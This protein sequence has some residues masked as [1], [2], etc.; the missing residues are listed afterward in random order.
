M[1]SVTFLDQ[2]ICLC[3]QWTLL[4]LVDQRHILSNMIS[5][6]VLF[7]RV[8]ILII[9]VRKNININDCNEKCKNTL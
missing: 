2:H 6:R 5:Y 4:T 7:A 3:D 8:L 1:K 9:L